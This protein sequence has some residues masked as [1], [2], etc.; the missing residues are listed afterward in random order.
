MCPA[1]ADQPGLMI[2]YIATTWNSTTIA[3]SA[4]ANPAYMRFGTMHL[5]YRH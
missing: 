5:Q 2:R 1:A 4:A 3:A